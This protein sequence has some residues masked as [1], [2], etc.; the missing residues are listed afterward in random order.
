M[1]RYNLT[2]EEAEGLMDIY[3]TARNFLED[4]DGPRSLAKYV[5]EYHRLICDP[6]PLNIH[7]HYKYDE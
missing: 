2:D 5:K 1:M 7:S 4:K 6:E 3:I